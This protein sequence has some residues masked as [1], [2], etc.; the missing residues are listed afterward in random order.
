MNTN[1]T[2]TSSDKSGSTQATGCC[3]GPAPAGVSACCA[4]DAASK[5]AGGSGCECGTGG[6]PEAP[7][8]APCCG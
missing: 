5:S 1:Q 7:A 8:K 6:Q 4:Q 2:T 3:G